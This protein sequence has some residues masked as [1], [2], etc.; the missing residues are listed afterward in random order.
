M[1]QLT[2]KGKVTTFSYSY[3][4]DG[5][6]E[7]DI[8][9]LG[10]TGTYIAVS[11]YLSNNNQDIPTEQRNTET[12]NITAQ[13]SFYND[14]EKDINEKIKEATNGS[15]S[16][17]EIPYTPET[18]DRYILYG[19]MYSADNN[20]NSE[21][22]FETFITLGLFIDYINNFIL[23]RIQSPNTLENNQV[24]NIPRIICD[25]EFCKS[26][27]FSEIVSASPN[28]IL[29]WPGTSD[30]KFNEYGT[31]QDVQLKKAFSSVV[32]TSNGLSDVFNNNKIFRP[33]RI[34]IN[35]KVIKRIIDNIQSNKPDVS[36]QDM[37]VLL[38]N[39]IEQATGSAFRIRLTQHPELDSVLYYYDINYYD[40][41][42]AVQEFYLPVFAQDGGRTICRE[43]SITNKVPDTLKKMIYGIRGGTS[44]DQP[45][46]LTNAYIYSTPDERQ[47]LRDDHKKNHANA[48]SD[49]A[50]KKLAFAQQ[51]GGETVYNSLKK[52]LQQYITYYDENIE[53][54]L[55]N[56]KPIFPLEISFTIDGINGFKYGDVLNIRGIPGRYS[57]NFVFM[58]TGISHKVNAQ[59][60]WSTTISL[61]SRVRIT[62]LNT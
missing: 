18:T 1:N 41:S 26:I 37:L 4:A 45:I 25:D 11:S 55:N 6:V 12:R 44:S 48:L 50:K 54:S 62:D 29:L 57:R 59:G 36:V 31:T 22:Q 14:I 19:P 2:F 39:E 38:S 17:I 60:N 42:I 16:A 24:N 8:E 3:S 10:V 32:A 52:S 21:N 49:L 33:S 20:I 7:V 46:T 13:N 5:S 43:V 53:T 9:F 61:V 34:Y 47:K 40:P 58:I 27:Y 35:T 30:G 28:N 51:P 15:Y 23:S 56:T